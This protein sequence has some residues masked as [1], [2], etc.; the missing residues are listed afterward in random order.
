MIPWAAL[1]VWVL[2]GRRP[3]T[4]VPF[5]PLW[6]APEEVRRPKNRSMRAPPLAVVLALL[7]VLVAILAGARPAVRLGGAGERVVDVIVDRGA[8]MS[9]WGPAGRA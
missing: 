1:A 5:L 6:D 3:R 9:G 7:A 2:I 4:W 8:T